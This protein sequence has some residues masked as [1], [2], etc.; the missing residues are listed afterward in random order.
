MLR[1]ESMPTSPAM[2]TVTFF[3]ISVRG[4][5]ESLPSRVCGA[6]ASHFRHVLSD[7]LLP[8]NTPTVMVVAA[9]GT[10]AIERI[11]SFQQPG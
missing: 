6:A 1:A 7:G 9:T 4:G 5:L 8:T 10:V 2:G 3:I 11:P